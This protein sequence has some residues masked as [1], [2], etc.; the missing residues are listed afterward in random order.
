MSNQSLR[1]RV[2]RLA[3]ARPEFQGV[4]LPLLKEAT[5]KTAGQYD[6]LFEEFLKERDRVYKRYEAFDG[7]YGDDNPELD[8]AYLQYTKL[9][10]LRVQRSKSYPDDK[11][12]L[13]L[14]NLNSKNVISE[15]KLH[16]W[17]SRIS[18]ANTALRI[19]NAA[20][21]LSAGALSRY[22]SPY[23]ADG[24]NYREKDYRAFGALVEKAVTDRFWEMVGRSTR[25]KPVAPPSTKPTFTPPAIPPNLVP[26]TADGWELYSSVAGSGSAARAL[27]KSMTVA[28]KMV[29]RN[30]TPLNKDEKNAKSLQEITRRMGKILDTYG[31]W[32]ARDTEPEGRVIDVLEGYLKLYLDR[33]DFRKTYD[34][35]SRGYL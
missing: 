25:V 20:K 6:E 27:G 10:R 24:W 5:E 21:R 29:G 18:D 17:A 14:E 8:E 32:G 30:V 35:L 7:Q 4:L 2:I 13:T 31:E 28:L 16:A 23:F 1:S 22:D 12:W 15:S 11:T 3:H 9:D 26:T 19:V 33:W 34:S